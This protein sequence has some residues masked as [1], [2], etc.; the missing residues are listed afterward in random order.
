[1]IGSNF[2]L[3]WAKSLRCLERQDTLR[4]DAFYA[5]ASGALLASCMT[6]A[7]SLAASPARSHI[8]AMH[9]GE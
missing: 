7:I 9:N 4:E 1:M 5:N 8:V 3:R 2:D 6:H